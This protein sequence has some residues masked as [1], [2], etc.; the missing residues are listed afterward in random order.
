MVW[1]SPPSWKPRTRASWSRPTPRS[2]ERQ[3][4]SSQDDRVG[5]VDVS[6]HRQVTNEDRAHQ[7]AVLV[8]LT[9]L[10]PDLVAQPQCRRTRSVDVAETVDRSDAEP[11]G[12]LAVHD[13]PALHLG[14]TRPGRNPLARLD[15]GQGAVMVAQPSEPADEAPRMVAVELRGAV[16]DEIPEAVVAGDVTVGPFPGQPAGALVGLAA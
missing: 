6:D 10:D 15:V 12:R 2:A 4:G 8:H 1:P 3:G 14:G 9:V 16:G 7:V 11:G 13:D 5:R